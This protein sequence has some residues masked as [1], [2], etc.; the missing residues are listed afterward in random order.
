MHVVNSLWGKLFVDTTI[1]S[2]GTLV[3]LEDI[4]KNSIFATLIRRGSSMDRIEVS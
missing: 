3:S 4:P 2:K 1:K